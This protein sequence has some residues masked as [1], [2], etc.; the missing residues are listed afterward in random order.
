MELLFDI[1]T[2]T[3]ISLAPFMVLAMLDEIIKR[4]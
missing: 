3:V 2:I 4:R 1:I